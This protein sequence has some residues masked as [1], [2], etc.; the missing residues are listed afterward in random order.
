MD[1]PIKSQD[2]IHNFFMKNNKNYI[3]FTDNKW[4]T[5]R[6]YKIHIMNK[7][8]RTESEL[9][10]LIYYSINYLSSKILYNP[11]S[12][13]DKIELKKGSNWFSITHECALYM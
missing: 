3:L 5:N 1:L 13:F 4:D 11:I 9:K 10:K 8:C 7:Y 2:Y 6:I 12:K